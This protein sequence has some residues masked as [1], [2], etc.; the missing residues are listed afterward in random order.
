MKVLAWLGA[1]VVVVAAALGI[2]YLNRE[3]IFIMI[4]HS[5]LPH[6]EPNHAVTWQQGPATAPAGKRPPNI[7]FILADDMGYNRRTGPNPQH[8]LHRP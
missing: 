7:V 2:A 1:I 6:I 4:A 8:R 3:A 5:Q